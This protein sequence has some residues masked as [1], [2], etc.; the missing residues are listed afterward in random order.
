MIMT[1]VQAINRAL[2]GEMERD[3]RVVVFGEERCGVGSIDVAAV[4]LRRGRVWRKYVAAGA[5]RQGSEKHPQEKNRSELHRP[6]PL[7]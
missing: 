5:S 7:N 3:D 6:P 2:A 4:D 1:M